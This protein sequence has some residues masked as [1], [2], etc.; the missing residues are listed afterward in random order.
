VTAGQSPGTSESVS[1]Q[2]L[3]AGRYRLEHVAGHGGMAIVY[4]AFDTVLERRVAIKYFQT[5]LMHEPVLI[6]RFRREALAAAQI[7]HPNV[8]AIHDIG[9]GEL[10]RPFMV[11]E[12]VDGP[13]IAQLLSSGALA[14]ERAVTL[15]AGIAHGL[16]AAH[17]LGLV[18][19]DVKPANILVAEGDIA[20]L[21]DFG[22]VRAEGERGADGLAAQLT[23]DG[24]FVGSVRYVAPEQ[25]QDGLWSAASDCY[26]LGATLYQMLTGELPVAGDRIRDVDPEVA[27][28]VDGLLVSDPQR[29]EADAVALGDELGQI[30][31]RLRETRLGVDPR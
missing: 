27:A 30:A 2:D 28:V 26:A 24:A 12:Y 25:V 31:E 4:E 16:G 11:L 8:V 18:H 23:A 5:H 13:T 21:T 3:L 7:V 20:K 17:A 15:A 29:R 1:A 9:E 14:V 6:E 22:L 19:R 10:D